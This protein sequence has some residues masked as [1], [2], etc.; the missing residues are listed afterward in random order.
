MPPPDVVMILFPLKEK[1][2]I[3]PNCPTCF[4]W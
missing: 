3:A 2:P 4:P 1:M